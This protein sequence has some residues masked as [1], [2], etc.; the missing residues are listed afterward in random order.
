[1]RLRST[2]EMLTEENLAGAAPIEW[3]KGSN[4]AYGLYYEPTNVAYESDGKPPLMVLVHGGP[5]A[6]SRAAW[7]YKVQFFTSRGFAVLQVNHRGSTGYGREFMTQLRGNWGKF[8]VEDCVSGM[9]FLVKQKKVDPKLTA[10]M[11]GSARGYTVLQ[12]MATKPEAFAV[13]ISMYGIA[14]QFALARATHK[15]EER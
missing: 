4:R 2:G 15:F 3:G 13:G 10:I 8:D 12:T 5:T 6:Q 7:D 11:G 14:D 9:E 1:M